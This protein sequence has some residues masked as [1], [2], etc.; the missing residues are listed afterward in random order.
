MNKINN[1]PAAAA[2]S[3]GPA[4]AQGPAPL[5]QKPRNGNKINQHCSSSKYRNKFSFYALQK[6]ALKLV[7]STSIVAH[8]R[9]REKNKF[10]I[11][12]L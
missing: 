12:A 2:P 11:S 4:W 6:T 10:S 9:K 3:L 7:L 8:Q 5:G 1:P